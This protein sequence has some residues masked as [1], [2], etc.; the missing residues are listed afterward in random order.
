M[1]NLK[2]ILFTRFSTPAGMFLAAEY[3]GK[4]IKIS[5]GEVDEVS[6]LYWL[7]TKMPG[8][9]AVEDI[10]RTSPVLNEAEK[11]IREYLE[12]KRKKLDFPYEMIG[13]EFQKEVWKE[14]SRIP[15]GEIRSYGELADETGKP[16][17]ARA[18][19]NACNRNPLPIIIPCHRVVGADGSLVG[20]G[21]GIEL[22]DK[23]LKLE[24]ENK[25]RI[26]SKS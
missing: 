5:F 6:F 15:Y 24:K 17:A 4:I 16:R 9:R 7:E 20:F 14:M 18:V 22:K 11:Q 2:R 19:G 26:K 8:I 23:L 21:G 12:G 3:E 25:S 1:M 13:T 10:E